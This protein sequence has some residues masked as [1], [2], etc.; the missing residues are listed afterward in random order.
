MWHHAIPG[1]FSYRLWRISVPD[2]LRDGTKLTM[3]QCLLPWHS[4]DTSGSVEF[5]IIDN[6]PRIRK[7]CIRTCSCDLTFEKFRPTAWSWRVVN[8]TYRHRGK[9]SLVASIAVT[10]RKTINLGYWLDW[11]RSSPKW[12]GFFKDQKR[13]HCGHQN[14]KQCDDPVFFCSMLGLWYMTLRGCGRHN[15]R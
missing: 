9:S 5:W 6:I 15:R 2:P 13:S 1:V 14:G 11:L 10:T 7:E 3:G 8:P 12:G 4:R